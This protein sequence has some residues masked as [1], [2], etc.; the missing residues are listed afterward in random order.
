MCCNNAKN[1]TS[2]AYEFFQDRHPFYFGG[3][4]LKIEHSIGIQYDQASKLLEVGIL[5]ALD[6]LIG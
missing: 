6:V 2:E 4:F 3:G 1:K 5:Y